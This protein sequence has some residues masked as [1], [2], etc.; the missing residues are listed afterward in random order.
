L[1]TCLKTCADSSECRSG[2]FC[3]FENVCVF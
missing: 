3:N 2:Y 1:G